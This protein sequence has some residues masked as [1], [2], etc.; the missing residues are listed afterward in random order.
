MRVRE[1]L[2]AAGIAVMALVG[3]SSAGAQTPPG[4]PTPEP[5]HEAPAAPPAAAAVVPTST[6]WSIQGGATLKPGHDAV[7]AAIGWPGLRLGGR[8][9]L[10]MGFE[11]APYGVFNF[12]NDLLDK[13][14]TLGNALGCLVKV[15]LVDRGAFQLAVQGDPSFRF[16]YWPDGVKVGWQIGFPE[17]LMS[18]TLTPGL[19]LDFGFKAPLALV[20]DR[21][22]QVEVRL[23]LLASLGFEMS[24]TKNLNLFGTVDIGPNFQ[25]SQARPKCGATDPVTGLQSCDTRNTTGGDRIGA[26]LNAMVGVAYRMP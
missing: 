17:V 25:F 22:Y 16:E 6:A 10:K 1:V 5:G 15:N 21:D 4:G 20:F 8:I 9:P 2:L 12:W 14:A 26:Y 23:P 11:V 19:D 13:K 24:L 7:E 18:Y 3:S